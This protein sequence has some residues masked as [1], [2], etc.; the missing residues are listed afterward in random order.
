MSLL[1]L[2]VVSFLYA[3]ISED[4]MQMI[5]SWIWVSWEFYMKG[6]CE[7]GSEEVLV[8]LK[9]YLSL[10]NATSPLET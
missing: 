4:Q 2:G 8:I 7:L 10:S 6:R 3:A 1:L 5:F 9:T